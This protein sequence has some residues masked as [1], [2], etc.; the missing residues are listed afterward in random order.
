[1]DVRQLHHDCLSVLPVGFERDV[2]Q[3]VG[4]VTVPV[5]ALYRAMAGLEPKVSDRDIE[6]LRPFF[7]DPAVRRAVTPVRIEH[8]RSIVTADPEAVPQRRQV[9]SARLPNRIR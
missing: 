8:R 6:A 2:D 3:V 5:Q 7:N 9:L 4:T 1:M